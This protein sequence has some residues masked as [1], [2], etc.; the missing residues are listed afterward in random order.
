MKVPLSWLREFVDVDASAQDLADRLSL[1]GLAVEE[2]ITTGEGI[3]GILAGRVL[4]VRD[5]P[6]SSKPLVLVKADAGT[7]EVL[8][9]VCGAR[10]FAVGDMVPVAVPGATLPGGMEIGRRK[11]AGEPSNGMLCSGRELG[12]SDD[13]SGIMIL[14][15]TITLGADVRDVLGLDDTILD[16]DVTPN[17]PDCL[18][19]LG[20]AREVAASYGTKLRDPIA[21][22]PEGEPSTADAVRIQIEDPEGCPS[23][24]ARVVAGISTTAASPWWMR[25]RLLAC[26]MRPIS[27]I[28]D[29]TNYVM[30][31][32]GQPL[33]AFDLQ[34]VRGAQIVVRSATHAEPLR[35]LDG[36]DRILEP[37]DLAICDG[38]GPVAFA[39]VIGGGD[40]EV[41]ESTTD[42]LLESAYFDPIRVLRTARRL[43]VR[44]EASVR[45]E[46]GVDTA[47][48]RRA[49][50]RAAALIA[51][52]SGGVVYRG[53]IEAGS[54]SAA[55]APIPLSLASASSLLGITVDE[56][57]ATAILAALGCELS[58]AGPLTLSVTSPTW[59][60]DLRIS[61]DLIEEI[62][63]HHGYDKIPVTLPPGGR[64]GGLTQRQSTRRTLRRAILGSGVSEAQTLS[65]IEPAWFDRLG[66]PANHAWR[67]V[68]AVANPLSEEESVLRSS[69]IPGLVSAAQRNHARRNLSVALFE[70]GVVFAPTD[71]ELPD[72]RLQAAVVLTGPRPTGWHG[73]SGEYDFFDAKGVVESVAASL[74]IAGVTFSA[75]GPSAPFHPA[76]TAIINVAGKP[77]G[78]VAELLPSAAEAFNLSSRVAIAVLDV[79]LWCDAAMPARNAP[80]HR[81]PPVERDIAFVVPA[82]QS[83][84]GVKQELVLAAGSLLED[85]SLFDVYTGE[86]AGDGNVSLAFALRFRDPERTLTDAEVDQ[87]MNAIASSASAAGWTVRD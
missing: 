71:Q 86:Q 58:S 68:V 84:D 57:Q 65:L 79:D 30:L 12:I 19:I 23:Y 38:E 70:I 6:T 83:A 3:S 54:G 74:G 59:R 75:A 78:L 72:E 48:Q 13:H 49:A 7:G 16:V 63:R 56:S 18:S 77:A 17:R 29:V 61:E 24:V 2:I 46:R 31:E 33:H 20:I 22:L 64:S 44:T 26:G 25:R 47:G 4:E 85:V 36:V 41:S 39:G 73:P 10:N 55:A 14:D 27:L 52:I 51:E 66:L 80:L 62:A 21:S 60:P 53:A 43:G 42:I 45:F 15:D 67:A 69:L 82:T 32:R 76:R 81:F 37:T 40:S 8:D 9:I 28:V 87:A 5:H 34:K 35:T 1:L 11:L 50:D